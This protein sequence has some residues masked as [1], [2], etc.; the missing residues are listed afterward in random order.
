MIFPVT[1]IFRL[2]RL[3][4]PVPVAERAEPTEMQLLA[5][6]ATNARLVLAGTLTVDVT[7]ILPWVLLPMVSRLAVIWPIS[8]E[9][10]PRLAELSAPPRFTPAPSVWISTFPANVASTMPVRFMLL[11][12]RVI[13][14]ALEYILDPEL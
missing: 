14:P 3:I 9:V 5:I 12:V 11:A 6:L 10:R 7:E 4:A 2:V 1:E 13:R 8:A